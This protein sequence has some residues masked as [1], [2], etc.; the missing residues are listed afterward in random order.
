MLTALTLELEALARKAEYTVEKLCSTKAKPTQEEYHVFESLSVRFSEVT[1]RFS[2]QIDQLKGQ[3]PYVRKR[4]N[5]DKILSFR[6][7]PTKLCMLQLPI[8]ILNPHNL[9]I[10]SRRRNRQL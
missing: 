4:R 2:D 10:P 6:T 5:S 3:Y 8:D 7:N 9:I 1:A